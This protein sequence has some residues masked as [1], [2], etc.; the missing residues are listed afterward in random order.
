MNKLVYILICLFFVIV[1]TIAIKF[2]FSP[3]LAA[4]IWSISL[5]IIL[6]K[7]IKK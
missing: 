7:I 1:S 4:S 6:L 3:I 5:F 2:N